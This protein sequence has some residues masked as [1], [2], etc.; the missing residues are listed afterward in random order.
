[1]K[2]K[3]LTL[4]AVDLG[5]VI[6]ATL[7]GSCDSS[8]GTPA[9]NPDAKSEYRGQWYTWHTL[10]DQDL[11]HCFAMSSVPKNAIEIVRTSDPSA[12]VTRFVNDAGDVLRIEINGTLD[13]DRS[14]TYFTNIEDCEA[15]LPK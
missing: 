1:M 14:I 15:N 11:D 4:A 6:I 10:S 3:Q 13:A 5:A 9:Q 2:S 8:T 12:K 7:I